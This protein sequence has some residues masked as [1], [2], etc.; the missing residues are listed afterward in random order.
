[1]NWASSRLRGDLVFF[2]SCGGK[3]WVPLELQWGSRG[4]SR[5]AKR[6]S[7]LLPNC[8]GELRIALESQ[9]GKSSLILG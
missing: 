4:T 2:S 9:Q 1:M 6:E 8:L 7:K 5:V 3:L